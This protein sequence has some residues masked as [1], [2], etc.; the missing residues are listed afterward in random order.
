[1]SWFGDK[2]EKFKQVPNPLL[3]H[4]SHRQVSWWR[5]ARCI[6]GYLVASVD[7]LGIHHC[8]FADSHTNH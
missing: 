5:R 6:I 7:R 1:M 4:A 3:Q 2:T 8:R